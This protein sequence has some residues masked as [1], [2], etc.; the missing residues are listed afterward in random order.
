MINICMKKPHSIF[1]E[2]RAIDLNRDKELIIENRADNIIS[3]VK[4]LITLIQE[5]Y[6][7]KTSLDLQKRLFASLKAVDSVKFRRGMKLVR[8]EKMKRKT[9]NGKKTLVE[10]GSI[11]NTGVIHINEIRPTVALLESQLGMDLQNNLLGSA[12]KKQF[13]GDIDIAVNIPAN[14]VDDF[15]DKISNIPAIDAIKKSSVIMTRMKIADYD[16]KLKT[17]KERTGFVQVDFMP[18]NDVSWLKTYYHSPSEMESKYRGEYRNLLMAIWLKYKDL[19]KSPEK[20]EDGRPKF[21]ER[22][23]WSPR[24]GL[25]KIR[26]H[27]HKDIKKFNNEIIGGPWKTPY[28]IQKT[29]GLKDLYG[30]EKVFESIERQNPPFM[31]TLVEDFVAHE[32]IKRLGVPSEM[33]KYRNETY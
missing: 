25:V 4:N 21:I 26:R 24:D 19:K 32:T 6:D 5:T 2:L 10:G 31:K 8:N 23:M 33:E 13:S 29:L 18:G 27:Y 15:V 1:E 16:S 20:F 14:K 9:I 17:D 30:F 12:G 11:P 22:Y 3:G 28:E 7:E